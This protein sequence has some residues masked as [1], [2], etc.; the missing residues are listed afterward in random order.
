MPLP[1]LTGRD[2]RRLRPEDAL[3]RP[4]CEPSLAPGRHYRDNDV[5]EGRDT[6]GGYRERCRCL[7]LPLECILLIDY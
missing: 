7:V 1:P 2:V 3:Q 6:R 5:E 4:S